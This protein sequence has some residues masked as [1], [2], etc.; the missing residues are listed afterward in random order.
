MA[1]LTG[2]LPGE[3]DHRPFT[4]LIHPSDHSALSS[5]RDTLAKSRKPKDINLSNLPRNV[6]VS[7]ANGMPEPYPHAN[8]KVLR[9]D[10]TYEWFN[11]R[12]H[13]GGALGADLARPQTMTKA[14][15]VVS[16]LRLK[17]EVR[18]Q[19]LVSDLPSFS[20]F[21]A[22]VQMPWMSPR[23][24]QHHYQHQSQPSPKQQWPMRLPYNHEACHLGLVPPC[25]TCRL[26]HEQLHQRASD[27]RRAWE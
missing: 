10:Q 2:F 9:S 18:N 19:P 26:P 21:T 4:D 27:P 12:F 14:Y 20:S 8:V 16:L 5:L 13:I 17:P 25:P 22:A 15:L 11:A 1:Q 7:P 23:M 6:L 3:V 24:D